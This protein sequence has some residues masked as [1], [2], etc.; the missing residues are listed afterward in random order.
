MAFQDTI[1]RL[2]QD[3]ATASAAGD[4]PEVARLQAELTAALKNA[5]SHTETVHDAD[6]PQANADASATT[7]DQASNM[8][9]EGD[10]PN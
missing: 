1:A 8:D 7:E 5:N 3:I 9:Y 2:R 4:Q 10:T 6:S